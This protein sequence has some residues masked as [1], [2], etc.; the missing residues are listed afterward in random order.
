MC[1]LMCILLQLFAQKLHSWWHHAAGWWSHPVAWPTS[2]HGGWPHTGHSSDESCCNKGNITLCFVE[3]VCCT[4]R[5]FYSLVSLEIIVPANFHLR[6]FPSRTKLRAVDYDVRGHLK[7]SHIADKRKNFHLALYPLPPSSNESVIDNESNVWQMAMHIIY[8]RS[9][10]QMSSV[11]YRDASLNVQRPL[12]NEQGDS[13]EQSKKNAIFTF[14][15]FYCFT[16][17]SKAG[18]RSVELERVAVIAYL[19][20]ST[21]ASKANRYLRWIRMHAPPAC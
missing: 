18:G 6:H 4:D 9:S 16:A 21:W 2:H 12:R 19:A 8:P 7:S 3:N 5:H 13:L 14:F 10:P 20:P 1:L 17:R 11:L 15:P